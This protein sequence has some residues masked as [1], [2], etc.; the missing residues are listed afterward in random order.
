MYATKIHRSAA[1][2]SFAIATSLPAWAQNGTKAV[3]E[4]ASVRLGDPKL[5]AS[6]TITDRR[7]DLSNYPT[8][9]VLTMAFGVEMFQLVAPEWVREQRLEIHATMPAGATRAQLP[10]MLQSLLADR[11]GLVVHM[12]SRATDVYELGVGKD[13][14]KMREVEPINGLERSPADSS[15]QPS[16]IDSLSGLSDNQTRTTASGAGRMRIG[17]A[18]TLYEIQTTERGSRQ[19]TAT[20]MT[21]PQL[22]GLVRSSVDK[23]VVD[24]TGLTGGY[25]FTIELPGSVAASQVASVLGLTKLDGDAIGAEPSGV[26]ASKAM[27][28]LGLKLEAR[29]AP[30][31]FLVVDKIERN[32]TAN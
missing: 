7:L 11:L 19:I 10:E 31:M 22:I 16:L 14:I 24:K 20:R 5:P 17:T 29:R 28:S 27:E 13:G 15:A 6:R 30:I 2:I 9:E 3:F 21:L 26:S 4:V 32:P 8:R 1:L 12:E 23:P 25:Q 18:A